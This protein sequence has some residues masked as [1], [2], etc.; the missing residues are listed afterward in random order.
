MTTK[1]RPYRKDADYSYAIGVFA[2]LEL[3][4]HK[5]DEVQQVLLSSKGQANQGVT[6]ISEIC[7]ERG[8]PV[9]IAD[10]QVERLAGSEGNYAIGVFDKYETQLSAEANHLVLV[11]PS[12]AGN[13][14]AIA[15]T[16]LGFEML[17]LAVIRPATDI[18]DPRTIRASM[19]AIFQLRCE[20]FGAFAE[21]RARF[22]QRLYPLMTDGQQNLGEVRP[23]APYALVFGN[24]GAGLGPEFH[25][26]GDSV[27]IAH[28][29]RIDSLN[30]AVSVGIALYVATLQANRL[31][32]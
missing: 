19:G 15:R 7:G 16:M 1:L 8:I 32:L 31:T 10:A 18:W 14:G 3:L 4:A 27:R 22:G 5:S 20:Y 23:E 25:T 9:R 24:E 28:S 17:D 30:L 6:K 26:L 13:L 11:N 29:Q 2:T 12:D 21:Y